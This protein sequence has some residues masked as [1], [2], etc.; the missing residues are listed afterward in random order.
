MTVQFP[1]R[2]FAACVAVVLLAGACGGRGGQS[3]TE[4]VQISQRGPGMKPLDLIALPLP[5]PRTTDLTHV[6]PTHF[7]SALGNDPTRIFEFVR[8][9][10]RFE[11]YTGVLRGPRGTLLALAGNSAD[12][13]ALLGAML[14]NGGQR[15]R[16]VRGRLGEK[17]A[18]E[19]ATT[20]WAEPQ[21]PPTAQIPQAAP[22]LK[23]IV[24]RLVQS[25]QRDFNLIRKHLSA[26]EPKPRRDAAPSFDSL[27]AEVRDHYWV[28]LARGNDWVDLDPSFTDS[29]P[30]RAY[31]RADEVLGTFP[32]SLFH[33]VRFRIGVEE[34]GEGSPSKREILSHTL[35]ASDL[36]GRA[37]TLAHFPEKWQGPIGSPG[38]AIAAAIQNTGRVKPVLLIGEQVFQGESF[39]QKAPGGGIGSIGRLLSGEGT[40][41]PLPLALAEF[42]EVDFLS[43]GGR[44]ETVV[45]EIYDSVGPARR[46][47][48]QPLNSEEIRIRSESSDAPDVATT[49]FSLFI[50]TGGIDTAHMLSAQTLPANSPSEEK[51][52]IGGL[53]HE[54]NVGFAVL[55]DM[56]A[57][58]I[59]HDRADVL[60][61][62]DSPRLTLADLT[63][64]GDSFRL[65]LDLRRDYA[66]GVVM[67][68]EP[69]TIVRA[70]MLRGVIDGTLE[71]TLL[72]LFRPPGAVGDGALRTAM[73][74]S[75]LFELALSTGIQTV[76]MSRDQI[77]LG[78]DVP[79]DA[80]ARV[81]ADIASGR[82]AVAPE[83]SVSIGGKQRFAWWR[84]DPISGETTAVTD[85]G[86]NAVE[87]QA[88]VGKSPANTQ[89]VNVYL[90]GTVRRVLIDSMNQATIIAIGGMPAVIELLKSQNIQILYRGLLKQ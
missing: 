29:N 24:D 49:I 32:Q 42:L 69:E 74:T 44:V 71:R 16:Y 26:V 31:A 12:R 37:V 55:S 4:Q 77:K 38:G 17:D 51:F 47:A 90:V 45:R 61:Y 68:P 1:S 86:L 84:I 14:E 5:V 33:Q 79:D 7:A 67:G 56:V 22:E 30:G 76:V 15:T 89:Q 54:L 11:V 20:M 82:V 63:Q 53:L 10:I 75:S 6:D 23:A 41:K 18:R 73:S 28:Q 2:T 50:T 43:P 60:F 58:R 88:E 27:V 85:E 65:T 70:R 72:E 48:G 57:G 40:R 8:D 21:A 62:Q 9:H 81:R 39:Y 66:R 13:A 80:Q 25:V 78:P 64:L 34:Y 19:L 36:S 35:R 87:L 59:R 46:S 3:R 52:D 83:R